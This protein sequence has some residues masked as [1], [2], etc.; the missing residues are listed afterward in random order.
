MK[1]NKLRNNENFKENLIAVGDGLAFCQLAYK[2]W[3]GDCFDRAG[4]N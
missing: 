1:K 2:K 4:V 3:N